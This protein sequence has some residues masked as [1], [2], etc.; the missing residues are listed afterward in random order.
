MP[1]FELAAE[2]VHADIGPGA[3]GDL[4]MRFNEIADFQDLFPAGLVAEA[5]VKPVGR[6]S[7]VF[8]P[9][10][11]GICEL[12]G[13]VLPESPLAIGALA[14]SEVVPAV[15]VGL[16]AEHVEEDA[17]QRVACQG[18]FENFQRALLLVGPVDAGTD[19]AVVHDGLPLQAER[20]PV[21]VKGGNGFVE[22]AE[23]EAPDEAD[24]A[25]VELLDHVGDKIG[26]RITRIAEVV[27]ELCR[28]VG[29][30]A[31]QVE[32]RHVRA[33]VGD[34]LRVL[35]GI[36]REVDLTQVGLHHAHGSFLPPGHRNAPCLSGDC[37]RPKPTAVG[38]KRLERSR[39]LSEATLP[40][41]SPYV[42]LPQPPAA[43]LSRICATDWVTSSRRILKS[44]S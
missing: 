6:V 12:P 21:R 39:H 11:L 30:D 9:R 23:I 24:A 13:R 32:K 36:E 44:T 2:D 16:V 38:A 8:P 33:K 3:D 22:L 41:T 4:A 14:G 10:D 37:N 34:R 19:L 42:I 7:G 17:V 26:R 35:L 25:P 5:P 18:F 15:V 20:Q 29:D 40:D 31:A 1:E 43:W 27:I 28:V